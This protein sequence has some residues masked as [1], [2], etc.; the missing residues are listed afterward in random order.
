MTQLISK[1][2]ITD[3]FTLS[4]FAYYRSQE[5]WPFSPEDHSNLPSYPFLYV[6]L[7]RF[8]LG[9]EYLSRILLLFYLNQL[10]WF[11]SA[12]QA[13][14]LYSNKTNAQG[15]L[16]RA[17][18][19]VRF[20]S[21]YFLLGKVISERLFCKKSEIE[22]IV[23]LQD[24]I[25][26]MPMNGTGRNILFMGGEAYVEMDHWLPH[27]LVG[28]TSKPAPRRNTATGTSA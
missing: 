19:L 18:S 12:L 11:F 3:G 8:H 17:E 2:E 27:Y 7:R 10:Q 6:L 5:I 24:L 20:Y 22:Q 25:Y 21:F 9:E 1:G 15:L 26:T 23:F 13:L 4:A 14:R 28:N 16:L